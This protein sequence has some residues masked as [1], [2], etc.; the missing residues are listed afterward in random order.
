[1]LTSQLLLKADCVRDTGGRINV[2]QLCFVS[3]LNRRLQ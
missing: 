1:M 2:G 3:L